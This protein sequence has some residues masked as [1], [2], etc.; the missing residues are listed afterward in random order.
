MKEIK[1]V[2]YSIINWLKSFSFYR[3]KIIIFTTLV[4]GILFDCFIKIDLQNYHFEY[5]NGNTSIVIIL[6]L[7]FTAI[8]FLSYNFWFERC[9]M[10]E[11][12]EN[13]IFDLLK[14]STISDDLKKDMMNF[15]RDDYNKSLRNKNYP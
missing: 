5:S 1:K 10:K 9:K 8:L 4:T 11:K 15:L 7:I 13:K 2:I 3:V 6:A 14:D 12:R